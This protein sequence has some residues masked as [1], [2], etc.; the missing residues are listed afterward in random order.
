[1]Y[2]HEHQGFQFSTAEGKQTSDLVKEQKD[3]LA[4]PKELDHIAM[5]SKLR[6]NQAIINFCTNDLKQQEQ[7]SQRAILLMS[8]FSF[9]IKISLM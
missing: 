1:M 6:Q 9:L 3:K 4:E 8:N 5:I 7:F 2:I